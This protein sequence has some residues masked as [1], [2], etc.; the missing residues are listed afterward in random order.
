[1]KVEVFP[2]TEALTVQSCADGVVLLQRDGGL[3]HDIS[4]FIPLSQVGNA[5]RAIS[6]AAKA[7]KEASGREQ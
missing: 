4:I 7:A 1:M 2:T 3:G 5:C 6:A